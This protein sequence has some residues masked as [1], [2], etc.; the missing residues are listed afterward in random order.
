MTLDHLEAEVLLLP[1]DSQ[2]ALLARLLA[3][4][5]QN[6][7]IDQEVAGVWVDEAERR[8][9]SIDAGNITGT[10]AVQVFQRVAQTLQVEQIEAAVVLANSAEAVWV[11]ADDVNDWLTTWGTDAEKTMSFGITKLTKSN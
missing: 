3:H 4:L 11:E 8:D 7:D 6:D 9:R 2:A 10:P 1:R 5:G